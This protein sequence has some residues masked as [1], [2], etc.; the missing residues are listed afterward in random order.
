M[1]M[2]RP[3][4][5]VKPFSTLPTGSSSFTTWRTASAIERMRDSVRVSRSIIA[6]LMPE[7][8]AAAMSFWLAEMTIS[9]LSQRASA[10]AS[11]ALFFVAV[12]AIFKPREATFARLPS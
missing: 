3:L 12:E 9:I 8:R 4:G 1:E 5:R 10:I 7:D 6:S 11:N 2:R